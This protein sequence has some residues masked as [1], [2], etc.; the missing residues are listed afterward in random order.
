MSG[1][2]EAREGIR[3]DEREEREGEVPVLCARDGLCRLRGVLVDGAALADEVHVAVLVVDAAHARPELALAQV[4]ER[5]CRLLASVRAAG[6]RESSSAM[7]R[8]RRRA[9][10]GGG[11][12]EGRDAPVPLGRDDDLLRV[13]RVRDRVVAARLLAVGDLVNLLTDLD[14][15]VAEGVDVA[16]ALGLG[17]LDLRAGRG[18][19]PRARRQGRTDV[20][21]QGRTSMAVEM[22]QE[23]VGGW[24]P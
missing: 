20:R 2:D 5:V 10:R 13:R 12:R 15:G 9:S 3:Y 19:Q 11:A 1:R 7:L 24:M 21:E 14:H 6:A 17:R 8:R 4:R 16:Q 22:G 23:Q 18:N